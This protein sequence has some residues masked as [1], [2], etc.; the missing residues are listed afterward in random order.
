MFRTKKVVQQVVSSESESEASLSG[1]AVH[2][3]PTLGY[4]KEV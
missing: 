4:E 3:L 2:V 1:D